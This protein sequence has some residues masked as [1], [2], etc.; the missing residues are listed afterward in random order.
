MT[1]EKKPDELGDARKQLLQE[2]ARAY[3]EGDGCLP[4][5]DADLNRASRQVVVVMYETCGEAWLGSV[6]L[7]GEDRGNPE[8]AMWK[9]DGSTTI[10]TFGSAFVAPKFDE[11]LVR[12]IM[13]RDRAPYTGAKD[14]Y[15]RI[16][17]IHARIEEIGGISLPWT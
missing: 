9:W 15:A 10:Y 2:F 16:Q 4:E 1:D 14:D 3:R 17:V 5:S 12:L 8:A 13:E 6:N 7:H 11:E